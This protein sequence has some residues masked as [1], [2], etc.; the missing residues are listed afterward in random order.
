MVVADIASATADDYMRPSSI[1][2]AKPQTIRK[3]L[4]HINDKY[5]SVNEYLRL[6][7]LSDGEIGTLRH[8]LCKPGK[9][10]VRSTDAD[11]DGRSEGPEYGRDH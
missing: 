5:G 10:P 7:G 4:Q 6:I 1:S 9:V 11:L 8:R 2:T 3:T